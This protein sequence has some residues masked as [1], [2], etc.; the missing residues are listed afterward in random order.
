MGT[1]EGEGEVVGKG[2]SHYFLLGSALTTIKLDRS[3]LQ[4]VTDQV[5]VVVARNS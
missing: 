2:R 3:R 5:A 4:R 1:E